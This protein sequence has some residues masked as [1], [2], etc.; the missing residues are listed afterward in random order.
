MSYT[1]NYIAAILLS[2]VLFTAR[3]HVK[4]ICAIPCVSSFLFCI[5]VRCSDLQLCYGCAVASCCDYTRSLYENL[6]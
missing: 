4:P 5:A 6:V 3:A 1:W 2:L